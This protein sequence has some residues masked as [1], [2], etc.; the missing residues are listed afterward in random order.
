MN[1]RAYNFDFNVVRRVESF[2]EWATQRLCSKDILYFYIYLIISIKLSFFNNLTIFWILR[3]KKYRYNLWIEWMEMFWY[4]KI[5]RWIVVLL[6]EIGS[7]RIS[8]T[9]SF[10]FVYGNFFPP[11]NDDSQKYCPMTI[12]TNMTAKHSI[13]SNKWNSYFFK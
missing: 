4:F 9:F 6:G 3:G 7:E 10:G 5:M 1:R 8:G 11:G 2:G 12:C 13:E